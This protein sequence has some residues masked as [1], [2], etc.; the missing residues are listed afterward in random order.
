MV[1]DKTVDFQI[2][3]KT[4]KLC[5]PLKYVWA[6]ERE[7]QNR[8]FILTV[9]AATEGIPPCLGDVYVIFKYALMGGS[10]GMKEE[11]VDELYL[12]AME[13]HTGKDMIIAAFQALEKSGAMGKRKKE[14]AA[15]A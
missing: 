3:G 12:A 15:L 8:N 9:N 4:Y 10:P 2:K 11:E 13:E 6:A 5:Y 1:L 7:L 14:Q